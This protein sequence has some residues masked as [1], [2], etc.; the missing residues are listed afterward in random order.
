VLVRTAYSAISAGTERS[1][2]ESRSLLARAKERPDLARQVVDRALR[3][4]VRAT[5]AAVREKLAEERPAGYSCAGRVAEVGTHVVGLS[6]GDLVACAGAGHAHHAE[7]VAV[8]RNLCARVPEGVSLQA[9]SLTT[10]ASIAMHGL[11]LAD[12]RLG[13]SVAVIGCG[14]VGQISCRLLRATGAQVI[15]LDIDANRVRQ[16]V[17]ESGADHGIDPADSAAERVRALTGG[18]DHVIVTAASATNDP[19]L[20]AADV[21]RERGSVTLVG[22]VPI[23]FPR[24]PMYMKELRFR[25]SRS[26]GP[27]RYDAEYEERGLD[28]P[29]GYVRWTERRN[30]ECVLDLQA[31]GLVSFESLIDEVVDVSAAAEAYARLVGPA[32]GRPRGVIVLAY[33]D[34]PDAPRAEPPRTT[35]PARPMAGAPAIG[36]IGAGGFARSVLIPAFREA[37]A[38]LELVGG[39]SGPSAEHAVREL[40]FARAAPSVEALLAD[41]S[42]DAVVVATRHGSHATIARDALRAGKHVF[43]EKPLALTAEELDGVLAAASDAERILTVGFNRRFSPLLAEVREFM[44][45]PAY[46][47]L[48]TYRVSAGELPADHWTHDLEQG[49]GRVHGEVCH[50]LDALAFIVGAEIVRVHSGGFG[51]GPQPLQAR[52]N[53][54]IQV[55]LAD[56]SVGSIV[57]AAVSVPGVA[58][59]R[60]E[61]FCH[62]RVAI[63]DDYRTLELHEGARRTRRRASGQQKGHAEE[64]HAFLDGMRTGVAPIAL[65]EIENVT[66]ATIA[67]V[68]SLRTGLPSELLR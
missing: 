4:G 38:R 45:A 54:A 13:E 39:G 8:P 53:L 6:V 14:L 51:D 50:F 22:A 21:A 11:R 23:D 46:P 42:I 43:C 47:L 16:A 35:T 55:E 36:L 2:I 28:Y 63:L 56:G 5:R 20:L 19:L 52:D 49:G 30:M 27:G 12:V 7:V 37:G 31:R 29:I 18:A 62:G 40:G 33:P 26:Y 67:A 44:R 48:A 57:Y 64:V 60:L 41:D 58:K 24:E 32:E 61:A 34:R 65:E 15:A 17:E 9:A 66:R 3:D 25:V 68:D 10:I 1:N 59:E